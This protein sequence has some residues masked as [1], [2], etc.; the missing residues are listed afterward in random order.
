[1]RF[2]GIHIGHNAGIAV[3]DDCG[4]LILYTDHERYGLRT[5]SSGF[6]LNN[7]SEYYVPQSDDLIVLGAFRPLYDC[8]AIASRCVDFD[9][10]LI[11]QFKETDWLRNMLPSH[12][13]P[14]YVADHHFCHIAS[15]WCFRPDDTKR[16]CMA[17]DGAGHDPLGHMN[18]YLAGFIGHDGFEK[19]YDATPIPTS[20]LLNHLL[21]PDSAGK[22]M[23]LA[24]HLPHARI[25]WSEA[26]VTKLLDNMMRS[27]L[28]CP[29]SFADF[30]RELDNPTWEFIAGFYRYW[31]KHI[32]DSLEENVRR[33]ASGGIVIGGGTALA[34]EINTKLYELTKEVVFGPPANDS[35]IC[36]GAAAIAYWIGRGKWPTLTSPS[37]MHLPT[38]NPQHGPQE[39][40]DIAQLLFN[41]SVVGLIRGKAEMGPR[42]LGYRSILAQATKQANLQRVSRDIKG[43]EY[44]RPL[45]PMVTEEAFQD[46]FVGPQGHYMEYRVVCNDYCQRHLKAIV[47]TD[48]SARPQ[49][50][51]SRSDPWLHRLLS[52]YGRL[53]G[54][55]CLIN[56]SLNKAGKTIAN[57]FDDA[58]A[59][60]AG[61]IELVSIQRGV[62]LI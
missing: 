1:M 31:T 17:Y 48:L 55:P 34:L 3:F 6:N 46:Y 27:S 32:Y 29:Y 51:S 13:V 54:H 30:S 36:L 33:F 20:V 62:K 49:V 23:G 40:E 41:D 39:P 44:Y 61:K 2:V 25:D 38:R 59:D 15:S 47:H 37:Q 24:G 60:M 50:V 56:T 12:I 7:V 19:I 10:S 9:V 11:G 57:T 52:E 4:K 53:S 43:R 5:K 16:F 22:S 58:Q 35:G 45:A 18:C 8:P 26:S 42:A 21:G 14:N 28:F